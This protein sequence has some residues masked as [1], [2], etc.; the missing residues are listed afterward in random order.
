MLW[1]P[2]S[3][4]LSP[5]ATFLGACLGFGGWCFHLLLL[6]QHPRPARRADSARHHQTMLIQGEGAS[7]PVNRG[8]EF[9]LHKGTHKGSGTNLE[10]LFIKLEEPRFKFRPA[11]GGRRGV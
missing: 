3:L 6:A 4:C 8:G 1:C 10:A 7:L 11:S 5:P 2:L 9:W